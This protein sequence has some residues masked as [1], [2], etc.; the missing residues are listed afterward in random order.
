MNLN[1][2]LTAEIY[3]NLVTESDERGITIEELVRWIIGDYARYRQGPPAVRMALPSINPM[4][5][6]TEKIL[7]LSGVFMKSMINQ[8]GIKCSNCTMPLSVEDIEAGKCSK[9]EAEIE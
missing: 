1:L 5:A 7:K 4:A 9:C 2:E 8:G 3:G 6:E